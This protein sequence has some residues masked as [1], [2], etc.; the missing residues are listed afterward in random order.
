MRK[1]GGGRRKGKESVK[2]KEGRKEEGRMRKGGRDASRPYRG[3]EENA[4][5]GRTQGP[6]LHKSSD[7]ADTSVLAVIVAGEVFKERAA[8]FIDLVSDA[9]DYRFINTF[10]F[11]ISFIH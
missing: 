7:L 11:I 5:I 9:E 3:D 4:K 10:W 6:P 8:V 2:G 1:L